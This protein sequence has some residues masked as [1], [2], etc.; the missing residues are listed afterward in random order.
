MSPAG[1]AGE[2]VFP[3]TL[4]ELTPQILTAALSERSPGVEVEDVEVVA[5][6]RCGEGVAS[7]ADRV[8]LELS[9]ADGTGA[10]VPTRL[11][12]KT[13]LASPHA[14]EAMYETEVRFYRELRSEL[15]I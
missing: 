13:M 15:E 11:V 7:T 8:V 2:V 12:L 1:R 14:P 10:D 4:E 5:A 9:Y 6:K 3:A